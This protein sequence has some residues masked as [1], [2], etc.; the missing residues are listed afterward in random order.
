[1]KRLV[2]IAL[3]APAGIETVEELAVREDEFLLRAKLGEL[4]FTSLLKRLDAPADAVRRR[5][6]VTMG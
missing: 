2:S 1:M 4:G 6:L 5:K 3:D